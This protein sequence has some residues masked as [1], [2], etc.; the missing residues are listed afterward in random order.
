MNKREAI[1][2]GVYAATELLDK[3]DVQETVES[4]SRGNVD[5]FGNIMK[6]GARL[7]F[8]PLEGLLGACLYGPGVLISTERP[9]PIQRFTG[10]HELGHVA[11][12]HG[13]SF[14]GEEILKGELMPAT[15]EM[16]VQANAFAAEFMLPRWL[17]AYHARRQTWNSDSMKNPLNVYQ[18]SLRVGASY[19]AA[20]WALEKHE[21]IT[22]ATA[23]T[24]TKTQPREIKRGLLPG[25]S[26]ANWRRDV[27]LLTGKDQGAFIEGQPDDLFLFRLAEQSGA[28]FIWDFETL[29]NNGFAIVND[30]REFPKDNSE[31]GSEVTRKLTAQTP[32]ALRGELHLHL[33]RPWDKTAPSA[34]EIQ[35]KYDLFGKEQGLPRAQ[36]LEFAQVA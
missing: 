28:G 32:E 14:D 17:L 33:K 29:K 15:E 26:P 6:E 31:I 20:I 3:L 19:E 16:E 2:S 12:H 25:Y 36:R 23:R 22:N 18:L 9:L 5:I 34:E 35:M 30:E 11:M 10:A 24:L 4:G 27:W 21:I 1:L 8:R 7:L 13:P